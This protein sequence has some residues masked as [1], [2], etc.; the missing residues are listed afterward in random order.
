MMHWWF[1]NNWW[2]AGSWMMLMMLV[3]W[4]LIIVGVIFLVRWLAG[5]SSRTP[6]TRGTSSLDI[7]S[8]RY[9]RGEITREQYQQMRRDIEQPH[10]LPG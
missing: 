1:N 8:E 10:S 7:L 4:A 5:Q 6:S 9:A 3:F 2:A